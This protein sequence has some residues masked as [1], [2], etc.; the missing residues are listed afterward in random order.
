MQLIR[1]NCC[2]I[3][4]VHGLWKDS[5]ETSLTTLWALRKTHSKDWIALVMSF[6]TDGENNSG[7]ELLDYIVEHN[8]GEIAVVSGQNPNSGNDLTIVLW[9]TAWAEWTQWA[10]DQGIPIDRTSGAINGVDPETAWY[11]ILRD[12]VR[13][14]EE[15]NCYLCNDIGIDVVFE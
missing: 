5:P 9:K 4:E 8:L 15:C 13:H 2:G 6:Q 1:M 7:Q 12:N 10:A 11:E 3:Y 14:L